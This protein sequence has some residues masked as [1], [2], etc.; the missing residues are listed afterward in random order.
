MSAILAD[1]ST[2]YITPVYLQSIRH[3]E[4]FKADKIDILSK[5]WSLS[6]NDE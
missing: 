4:F 2:S 5:G 1:L 3:Q 6:K